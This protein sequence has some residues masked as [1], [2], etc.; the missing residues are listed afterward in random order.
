MC[1]AGLALALVGLLT[2]PSAQA[3]RRGCEGRLVHTMTVSAGEVR[4]YKTR[5]H[6]CAVTIAHRPLPRGQLGVSIQPR[7][8]VPVQASAGFRADG[9]RRPVGRFAGPVTVHAISRCV[10]VRGH[11][12]AEPV[13][14][15]W[16]L[17]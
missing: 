13:S 10:F 2:A 6:A 8:G 1:A 16:V 5:T 11:V 14:S 7:G 9:R 17:C 15:G 12:G 3:A 4:L